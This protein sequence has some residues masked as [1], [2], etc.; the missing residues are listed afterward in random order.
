MI[1]FPALSY[2]GLWEW[3][4]HGIGR[5]NDGLGLADEVQVQPITVIEVSSGRQLKSSLWYKNTINTHIQNNSLIFEILIAA[6]AKTHG[7]HSEVVVAVGGVGLSGNGTSI[8]YQQRVTKA[9]PRTIKQQ[10]N[11]EKYKEQTGIQYDATE[12]ITWI[13]SHQHQSAKLRS[14]SSNATGP[15]AMISG[16][17]PN[18]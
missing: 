16:Q 14:F 11:S 15:K 4:W 6:Y 8:R 12:E 9:Q 1:Q 13:T 17:A 5:C 3:W 7:L 10:R 2:R 18:L